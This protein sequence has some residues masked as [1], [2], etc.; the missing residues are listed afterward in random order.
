VPS[1][2]WR[3]WRLGWSGPVEHAHSV[4]LYLLSPRLV[5]LLSL[6]RIALVGLFTFW[7]LR[8]V[9]TRARRSPPAGGGVRPSAPP[10]AAASLGLVLAVLLSAEPARADLPTPELLD[11]LK[12]RIEP[13]RL[14]DGVCLQVPRLAIQVSDSELRLNAEVHAAERGV[15]QLPGPVSRWLP[16]SIEVDG[17]ITSAVLLGEDGYLHVRLDPGRHR[18]Q[19]RGPITGRQL[20]LEPGT[21]ARWVTVDAPGW[22]VSGL[23][24]SGQIDGSLGLVRPLPSDGARAEDAEEAPSTLPTWSMLTRTFSFGVSWTVRT[25]LRRVSPKGSL[26]VARVPLLPGERV[27]SADV[28]TDAGVATTRLVGDADSV[29]FDSVLEPRP[30][31]VLTAVDRAGYSERWVVLCSP[32]FRCDARGMAPIQHEAAGRWAPVFAPWPGEALTLGVVRPAAAPGQTATIDS[33]RLE[34]HPGVRLLRGELTASVRVSTQTSYELVLPEGSEVD[35]LSVDG[36]SEPIR[37]EGSKIELVLSPGR[38]VLRV[39]WQDPG[40]L[41][42]LFRTPLVRLGSELINAEVSVHLPDERWLLA[43]GGGSWGPAILFWGHLV[44]ILLLAPVLA[45]V[46]RSPLAAWEWALLS[47]GLT[48]VPLPV[49]GLVFGWFFVIAFQDLERPERPFWFNVR[50]LALL[51]LT[52]LFLSCLFG[53]V[54][55]SLLN[56]PNMEVSGSGSSERLLHWYSD[57]TAGTLPEVWVL[58]LSLWVWRGVM[59]LWALWLAH[60]LVRW[61]KWAW[62]EL[63]SGGVWKPKRKAAA[64]ADAP[65]RG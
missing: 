39:A 38:H 28:A 42:A 30:E 41:S 46:P 65:T 43:A 29:A 40:G 51:G 36:K 49:A 59:L 10:R 8:L 16:G 55:D 53:A 50:Q 33:A 34:L 5:A 45:R 18:V 21:P 60:N 35:Q 23:S 2:S 63:S 61:L 25:E 17:R 26:I 22:E 37:Q 6:L 24:E 32:I 54:Y 9:W 20:S 7:A 58:T 3:S 19:A 4:E 48:Q 13:P 56:T 47:L 14:C 11:Q 62:L 12:T 64:P 1:W 31:L 15:Y 52:L 27:T 44:L 57:R